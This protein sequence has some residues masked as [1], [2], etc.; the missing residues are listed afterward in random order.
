MPRATSSPL[1]VSN[2][3]ACSGIATDARASLRSA[4]LLRIRRR[5]LPPVRA[6]SLG[7][8]RSQTVFTVLAPM[9][10]RT[11][12]S[13]CTITMGPRGVSNWRTSI[14]R[15][16]PPSRTSRG[17]M[18]LASSISSSLW[19]MMACRV[20]SKSWVPRSWIWP[21]MMGALTSAV[22]P[23]PARASF[24]ASDAPATTEGSSMTIGTS[25]SWPL[26][27]KL[28]AIPNGRP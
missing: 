23:P 19:S 7:A 18:V 25:T 20:A 1:K 8:R 13:T 5:T 12:T 26:I 2:A 6:S 14:S 16:P 22:N 24:A 28:V 4:R 9:A 11:S 27:R 21:I 17:S 3:R 15:T 10:S